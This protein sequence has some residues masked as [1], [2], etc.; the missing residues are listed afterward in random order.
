MN[1]GPRNVLWSFVVF[2]FNIWGSEEGYNEI[3]NTDV[4]S[5][6][7]AIMSLKIF[8]LCAYSLLSWT[9]EVFTQMAGGLCIYLF[10]ELLSEAGQFVKVLGS[11]TF[12]KAICPRL[13]FIMRICFT[14]RHVRHI[15][16]WPWMY[17]SVGA[18]WKFTGLK[19][20]SKRIGYVF[21]GYFFQIFN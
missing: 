7:D 21:L 3:M 10:R 20:Q 12:F 11:H 15:P 13:C 17:P 16:L 5:Y 8:D 2:I 18:R 1:V 4:K 9:W 14:T 19:R 6:N